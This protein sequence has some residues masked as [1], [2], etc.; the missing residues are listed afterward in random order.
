MQGQL[1]DLDTRGHLQD[2]NY[3]T[4][5]KA[6]ELIT[7]C[8]VKYPFSNVDQPSPVVGS[9]IFGDDSRLHLQ[10]AV[11]KFARTVCSSKRTFTWWKL[12]TVD[13]TTPP[14]TRDIGTTD[15]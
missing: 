2:S 7:R 10:T 6:G 9:I 13:S 11:T 4:T 5:P 3:K 12:S 14:L 15:H 8:T 1:K